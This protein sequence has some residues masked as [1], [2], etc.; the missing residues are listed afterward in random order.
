ML[1]RSR[2]LVANMESDISG[3]LPVKLS[4]SSI[5][6]EERGTYHFLIAVLPIEADLS[7]SK[8]MHFQTQIMDYLAT[9]V[10]IIR[11]EDRNIIYANQEFESM[12][13][14]ECD[15]LLGQGIDRVI[16]PRD[17]SPLELREALGREIRQK[18]HWKGEIQC[19]RKDNSIFWCK[20]HT[21]HCDHPVHGPVWIAVHE[22]ISEAK[23]TSIKLV[24]RRHHLQGLFEERT[25]ELKGLKEQLLNEIEQRKQA[26]E[27]GRAH[28]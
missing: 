25:L 3:S 24:G 4:A 9:G 1:F 8:S 27:I 14:Y 13:G 28:V 12:F 10:C 21:S 15:E 20:V 18:G 11:S 2:E 5:L 16:V 6:R 7:I 17:E 19:K 26:E 22:D 23:R